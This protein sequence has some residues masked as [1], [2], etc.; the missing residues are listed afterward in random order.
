MVEN[1]RTLKKLLKENKLENKE[2]THYKGQYYYLH[3]LKNGV[4]VPEFFSKNP[5]EVKEYILTRL[6]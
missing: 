1:L 4:P 6:N 5:A 3:I 2:V